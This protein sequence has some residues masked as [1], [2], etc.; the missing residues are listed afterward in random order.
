VV[1]CICYDTVNQIRMSLLKQINAVIN[2]LFQ[3]PGSARTSL[4]LR[5]GVGTLV[6]TTSHVAWH[7]FNA[8]W[9]R[10]APSLCH[11]LDAR[12]FTIVKTHPTSM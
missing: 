1:D 9:D 4:R 11:I 10:K 12:P 2:Q 6:N 5:S 7:D 8:S 3:V